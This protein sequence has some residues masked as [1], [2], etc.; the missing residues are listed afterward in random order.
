MVTDTIDTWF[1]LIFYVCNMKIRVYIIYIILYNIQYI[2]IIYNIYNV[3]NVYNNIYIY[4]NV[5]ITT[6][7]GNDAHTG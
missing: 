4:I 7:F 3:Y 1:S 5:Y 2:Y 6:M